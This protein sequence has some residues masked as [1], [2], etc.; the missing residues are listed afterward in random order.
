[1]EHVFYL[2]EPPWLELLTLGELE[3]RKKSPVHYNDGE[4]CREKGRPGIVPA[5]WT[6]E[7]VN[8]YVNGLEFVDL[9]YL[10]E[11]VVK[12]CG[13]F[14]YRGEENNF[15]LLEDRNGH[16]FAHPNVT[17]LSSRTLQTLK[18]LFHKM[19]VSA[20]ACLTIPPDVTAATQGKKPAKMKQLARKKQMLSSSNLQIN[21]PTVAN[22]EEAPK[23]KRKQEER[24]QK[25]VKRRGTPKQ[26]SLSLT[27]GQVG[28]DVQADI[29]DKLATYLENNTEVAVAMISFERGDSNL[30]LH[31]QGIVCIKSTSTRAVKTDITR[32][33]G[34]ENNVPVG[35]VVCIKSL[36]NK[37]LH[38]VT[39][40]IGYCLKDE[41]EHHFRMYAKNVSEDQ[42]NEGRRRHAVLGAS[43]YKNRVE[44][45]PQNILGRALQFR[46][47]RCKHPVTVNF[48]NCARE[49][50]A[51]GQYLPSFK[52]CSLPTI[53]SERA[54]RV[55]STAMNPSDTTM[56]DVDHVL[57]NVVRPERYW[58]SSHPS[59][60]SITESREQH[61]QVFK[62]GL[63]RLE[64]EMNELR[65]FYLERNG[66][67][68]SPVR[69]AAENE[70]QSDSP[71]PNAAENENQQEE[72]QSSPPFN[73]ADVK[74]TEP[75][76]SVDALLD[77]GY[78]VCRDAPPRAEGRET[79]PEYIDFFAVR[80]SDEE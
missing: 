60:L 4:V 44:L 57:F 38:T 36:T 22:V 70:K 54:E 52:W 14:R 9:E 62:D 47:F 76:A 21:N 29:F 11:G 50:F 51:S 58:R 1:M 66:F 37:G 23:K 35:G 64:K 26:L 33:I 63:E 59:E 6:S 77:I 2:L 5:H 34:W 45:T 41:S 3:A 46:R 10:D 12:S 65:R 25:P 48:R 16:A 19:S 24:Q 31:I 71:V 15:V 32:A 7:R 39:G 42:M 30:N 8:Y 67:S 80:E 27:V 61:E 13:P 73:F 68:D 69:N 28:T 74:R 78:A 20:Q 40:M 75:Q 56:Q 53:S 49:M 55:W 18:K 79:L 17:K 72:K 43:C